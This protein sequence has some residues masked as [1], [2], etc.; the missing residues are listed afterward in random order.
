MRMLLNLT[1]PR[2]PFNTTL[3]NRT[4]GQVLGKI[5]EAIQTEAAY[6]AEQG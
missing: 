4:A 1:L 5:L 3:R 6:F 2:G